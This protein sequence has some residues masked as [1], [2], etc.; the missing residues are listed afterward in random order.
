MDLSVSFPRKAYQDRN[1]KFT[2]EEC[3]SKFTASEPLPGFACSACQSC[4]STREMS[5]FR[6]PKI[7]VIQFKRFYNTKYRRAKLANSVE[8]PMNLDMTEFCINQNEMPH[9]SLYGLSHHTGT[10]NVGHYTSEVKNTDSSSWYQG[11]DSRSKK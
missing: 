9:Y 2:V 5:I 11:N 4:N 8:I 10:L 6:M 7:L 3:L 1:Y